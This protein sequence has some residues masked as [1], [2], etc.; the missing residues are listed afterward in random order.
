MRLVFLPAMTRDVT[1]HGAA[2]DGETFDTE[3]IQ[4]AIDACA[5][6]GGGVVIDIRDL[7]CGRDRPDASASGCPNEDASV[8]ACSG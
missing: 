8:L 1:A 3:P 5:D 2:G 6:D 7:S 4:S